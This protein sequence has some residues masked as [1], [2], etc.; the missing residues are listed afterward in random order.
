[1][2]LLGKFEFG[3]LLRMFLPGIVLLSGLIF[4]AD[5]LYAILVRDYA[6]LKLI[7]ANQPIS[8]ALSLPLSLI[9]GLLVN[10]VMFVT[11]ITA[12]IGPTKNRRALNTKMIAELISYG[13]TTRMATKLFA[14]VPEDMRESLSLETFLLP[15]LSAE[16]ILFVKEYFY[17]YLQFDIA[18]GLSF[19]AL[20]ASIVGWML[21]YRLKLGISAFAFWIL[22]FTS[23]LI[24][25]AITTILYKA[26]KRNYVGNVRADLSFYLGTLCLV[27]CFPNTHKAEPTPNSD[28]ATAIPKNRHAK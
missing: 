15:V 11:N 3:R 17:Y 5:A 24:W 22:F 6:L 16:R 28:K 25:I 10:T 12:K 9:C 23:V 14:L 1:M 27:N 2:D 13:D 4:S 8:L 20:E 21:A 26:A 19:T 7:A 18:F